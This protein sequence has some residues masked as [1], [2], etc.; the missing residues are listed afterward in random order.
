[1]ARTA[2][3]QR[4]SDAAAPR[5]TGRIGNTQGDRIERSPATN[6]SASAPAVIER[7]QRLVQQRRDRGAL[8][9]ADR[10]VGFGFALEGDQRR[11]HAR[12][13]ALHS[14]LLAVE[15]DDEVDEV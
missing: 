8:G 13:E 3:P 9:I 6:A 5:I 15:V 4:C 11:L 1:M 7:S 10:A 14:V 12:A 2:G